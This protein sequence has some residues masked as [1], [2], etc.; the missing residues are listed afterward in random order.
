MSDYDDD[1]GFLDSSGSE[2]EGDVDGKRKSTGPAQPAQPGQTADIEADTI[3]PSQSASQGPFRDVP[4]TQTIFFTTLAGISQWKN[5]EYVN[6][7]SKECLVEVSPG[8]IAA[9]E[10]V[11]S[12]LPP[13]IAKM[14]NTDPIVALHLTPGILVQITN[15]CDIMVRSKP[16]YDSQFQ[17]KHG[18]GIHIRF[19]TR[20]PSVREALQDH[21]GRAMVT[22]PTYRALERARPRETEAER[23]DKQN[24]G[25]RPGT[26]RGWWSGSRRTSSFRKAQ[27][28]SGSTVG[29]T[30]RTY[31]TTSSLK[32]S[33][34]Q[35]LTK[36]TGFNIEKSAIFS[37][38]R[39]SSG[40]SR[41]IDGDGDPSLAPPPPSDAFA[42]DFPHELQHTLR[43]AQCRVVKMEKSLRSRT[44]RNMGRATLHILH[45]PRKPTGSVAGVAGPEGMHEGSAVRVVLA[46]RESVLLDQVLPPGCFY[47]TPRGI[48]M[49]VFSEGEGGVRDRGGVGT[50]AVQEIFLDGVS[51]VLRRLMIIIILTTIQ[52]ESE[53]KRQWI[54]DTLT[55]GKLVPV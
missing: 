30:E 51:I 55:S 4:E 13:N 50:F 52:F 15:V 54:F 38:T 45:P 47:H 35:I 8:K 9:F 10:T 21:I 17:V 6:L 23:F 36:A 46:N 48:T 29:N 20:H 53:S 25:S 22:N 40:D 24:P 26:G 42:R 12:N 19:H 33:I 18:G 44:P 16:I 14:P 41:S 5:G 7:H 31:R 28:R 49:H 3:T 2:D 11:V 1:D 39:G 34:N 27:T 32:R 37:K 43:T